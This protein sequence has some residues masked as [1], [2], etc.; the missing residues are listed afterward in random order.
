MLFK[1]GVVRSAEIITELAKTGN[2]AFRLNGQL[3]TLREEM[4]RKKFFLRTSVL[5]KL[6][7]M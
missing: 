4:L 7:A 3:H 1:N 2:V 5:W 6:R